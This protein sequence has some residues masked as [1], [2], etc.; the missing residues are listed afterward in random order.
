MKMKKLRLEVGKYYERRDRKVVQIV[1]V[2]ENSF[3]IADD[4][5]PYAGDGEALNRFHYEKD[6][7]KEVQEPDEYSM[8]EGFKAMDDIAPELEGELLSIDVGSI[9]VGDLRKE[10]HKRKGHQQEIGYWVPFNEAP[11]DGSELIA[12]HPDIGKMLVRYCSLEE[13]ATSD[14]LK[15]LSDDEAM[16][17]DW[18]MADFAH[19]ER[20]T[21]ETMPTHFLEIGMPGEE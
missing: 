2:R 15:G 20:V 5:R 7:V 19:G 3:F 21:A 13:V 17:Q 8:P 1:E 11:K 14:E 18:F 6:L 16:E 9:T 12:W 4:A 10:L